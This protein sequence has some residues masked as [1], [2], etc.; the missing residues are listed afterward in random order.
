[1]REEIGTTSRIEPA[2]DCIERAPDPAP[3]SGKRMKRSELMNRLNF[4]NFSEG[5]IF[6]T[7]RHMERGDI[8][9]CQAFPLP[10]RDEM[11]DCRWMPPGI[12]PDRLKGYVCDGILVSDGHSHV[13]ARV[14]VI[15]L[16]AES[17]RFRISD[18]GYEKSVRKIDRHECEGIQARLVQA[19]ISFDG[20]LADFNA[21]SFRVEFDAGLSASRRWINAADPIIVM[22]SRDGELLYSGECLAA[23][24]DKASAKRGLVLVPNFNN[25]RRYRPQEFRNARQV[26]APAPAAYFVHPFT[27]KRVYL[28]VKDISGTGICVE[29][30]FER[31]V[32]LPGMIIPELSIEI[33]NQ[34]VMRCRA[35]V[36]YRNMT[37][38]DDKSS[39]VRCG[40]VILDMETQD[41]ARLS[42][43]L[44]NASNDR[45][46]VCGSLDMEEL[47]RFFF[48]TGF[49]YPAKY[50][51]IEAR[52]A[53]FK[54][55]Y[56]KLYLGSPSIARHF[57]YEDKGRIFGHMSMVHFYSNAW[58]IHHHAASRDGYGM[59][60]VEVLDQVGRY[61]NAVHRQPSAHMDYL[62]CYFREENRFPCRIFSGVARDI[63]DP[64][65][66]SLDVFAYIHLPEEGGAEGEPSFQLFPAGDE[67]L[68]EL[69][70][71]YEG[72]SGGLAL[73]ALDLVPNASRDI[74]IDAEYVRQGFKRERHIFSLRQEGK[75]K[76]VLSLTLSEL[77][78]NLSNLTNCVHAFVVDEKETSPAAL[79]A[80]LRTLLRHY[81]AE[82]LPVLVYPTDFAENNALPAEK[83]YTLWVLDTDRSDGYFGSIR[84]TFKKTCRDGNDRL[85]GD[86]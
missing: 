86:E 17:V 10:C 85:R 20:R 19:G 3:E 15:K 23:R 64:K 50:L 25:M 81:K 13:T 1:M 77:G 43:F 39:T 83:K 46:R 27:G 69:G 38:T 28:Q 18:S 53:E 63:A 66:S 14:E 5:T 2:S 75:L 37:H 7:F 68:A 21:L 42:A 6:A 80:G 40:I 78:L 12:S 45:L 52:K 71:F 29:E 62:M 56:E 57:I 32:L 73:D 22:L 65:G 72:R 34:S 47:W 26:L 24:S 82:D 54:S 4:I 44:H 30:F 49:I 31:S 41:Q 35:Q 16:D 48:E 9:S 60:G 67:D 8:L 58:I 70:R 36:L 74:D 51:S 11:L 79:M 61:T 76:A 84:A 59:A 33:A 55:T